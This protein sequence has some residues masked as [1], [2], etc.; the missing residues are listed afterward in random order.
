VFQNVTHLDHNY[1]KIM[2]ATLGGKAKEEM[3][4]KMRPPYF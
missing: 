3:Q 4:S 1:R 2:G